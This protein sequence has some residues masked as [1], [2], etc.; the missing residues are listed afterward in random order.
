MLSLPVASKAMV[1]LKKEIGL[2]CGCGAHNAISTW[3]FEARLGAQS[4]IPLKVTANIS[5]V[6]MGAD[7][8]LYGPVENSDFVFPSVY[9]IDIYYRFLRRMKDQLEV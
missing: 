2:P 3:N 4:A 8:I 9:A 7:F 5:P 1:E 6:V